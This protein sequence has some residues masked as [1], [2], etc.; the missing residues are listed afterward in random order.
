[1]FTEPFMQRALLAAVLL[2]PLCALLG[3]FVTARRLSFFSETI[4]HGALAGV[5]LGFWWG[6]VNPTIT[7]VAFSLGVAAAVLWLKENTELLTDTILAVVLSGSVSI[8]II[9]LSLLQGYQGQIQRYLFGDILAIGPNEVAGSA[10]LFVVVGAGILTNLSPLAL[11]TTS[12][13]MAHVCGVPLRRLNYLFVLTL[14]IVV[15]MSIRL[16]GI[17]LVTSLIVIPPA[18]ARNV[19]RNFRQ[20]VVLSLFVG[21]VGGLGGVMLAYRMDT[22][23]G[24]TIVLTCVAMF[25]LS[26]GAGWWRSRRPT[27]APS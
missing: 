25:L 8:G 7:V 17:I 23:C 16:L 27:V 1:M 22:P 14:A 21:L 2:A 9:L 15:A 18:A 24:P 19:T 11:L 6:L 26:L 13:D 12:E 10:V 3:V 20:H 5:G 4:A